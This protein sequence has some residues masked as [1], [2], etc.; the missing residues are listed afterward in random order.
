MRGRI[1]FALVLWLGG[2]QLSAQE[3]GAVPKVSPATYAIEGGTVHIG[4]GQVLPQA[5][6]V[7]DDGLITSVGSNVDVP[8]GAWKLDATGMSVYPGLIDALTSQGLKRD[9]A[10]QERDNGSAGGNRN[11]AVSEEGPGYFAH[12]AAA[13]LLDPKAKLEGW[14]K[15]G[16][17]TLHA[18]PDKGIF[19]GQTVVLNP[20]T[21]EPDQWIVR[22]PVAHSVAME[23]L[24]SRSFPDS[25]MGAMAHLR[26]TLLD[27]QHY[28]DVWKD[29]ST[30][31][32]GIK[33]PPTDRTLAALQPVVEGSLPLLFRA[34]RER[35][36]RRALALTLETGT[37][38]IVAGGF[39]AAAVADQLKERDIPVLLS[40]NYPKKPR[41]PHPEDEE[42][43]SSIRYRVQASAVGARL[44]QA[45][46][47]FAFC[48]DG[49]GESDFV[50]GIRKAVERGL[51]PEAALR[52]ATLTAAEI[53]GVSQQLGSLESGKIANILVSEG[54]LFDPESRLRHV[55]VDGVHTEIPLEQKPK[56]LRED[57]PTATP[58]GSR[59]TDLPTPRPQAM[60]RELQRH[61][62]TVT[63]QAVSDQGTDE[64][65]AG[66]QGRKKHE[67]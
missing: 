2:S 65:H 63:G 31:P 48:S 38:C 19:Q 10:K 46:V 37:G 6:V 27:A 57:A 18:A 12:I 16:V 55:F 13:D 67:T 14:K 33:R 60:L 15:A 4:D 47:R 1:H 26:Q 7:I 3:V 50:P 8:A 34:H 30:R 58:G 36:I 56:K 5:T 25:L 42:P 41:D 40:V 64:I 43:L 23:P 17:L 9:T 21:E 35:E 49:A 51:S 11:R 28:H 22:H 61:G 44:A 24:G 54:D 20:G 39:E 53:L 29:Y 66:H 59:D 62:T 32:R 52:A 45:G